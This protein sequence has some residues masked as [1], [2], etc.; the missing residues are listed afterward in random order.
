[1]SSQ[2]TNKPVSGVTCIRKNGRLL[3]ALHMVNLPPLL[4]KQDIVKQES[5]GE[6][7]SGLD[8]EKEGGGF[9]GNLTE[10]ELISARIKFKSTWVD[11]DKELAAERTERLRLLDP[12]LYSIPPLYLNSDSA[13]TES[14]ID[15]S[16]HSGIQSLPNR[17]AYAQYKLN[18]TRHT[19]KTEELNTLRLLLV[20]QEHELS[21][22]RLAMGNGDQ[23][24]S[25]ANTENRPDT[26]DL[27]EETDE[28]LPVMAE[29]GR[30]AKGN[31]DQ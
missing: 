5:G 21:V 23:Y 8:S 1:V 7:W 2:A 28:Q 14:T 30:L 17:F 19:C 27:E 31:G 22:M 26:S 11:I 24:V 18:K 16:L 29:D 20:K 25:R 15:G 12:R 9:R 10:D 13:G 3:R 4:L 6:A